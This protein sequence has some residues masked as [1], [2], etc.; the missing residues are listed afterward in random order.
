MT[1]VWCD[2][3][4]ECDDADRELELGAP[5]MSL[6]DYSAVAGVAVNQFIE[7]FNAPHNPYARAALRFSP[8]LLMSPQQKGIGDPRVIGAAAVAGIVV[9]GE[10]REQS[11]K[12]CDIRIFVP[13]RIVEGEHVTVFADV[14]DGRRAVLPYA[15]VTLDS[16][17]PDVAVIKG[18]ELGATAA[19]TT[20]ISATYGEIVR[21]VVLMVKSAS[22]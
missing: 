18:N 12:P 15:N 7:S 17:N 22:P 3:D 5:Q 11:R 14:V 10:S 20:V 21:R 16:T 6:S 1:S 8:F 13:D 19:G 9:I 4:A 2:D